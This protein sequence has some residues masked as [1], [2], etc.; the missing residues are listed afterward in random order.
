MVGLMFQPDGR[1]YLYFLELYNGAVVTSLS[2]AGW[3][4]GGPI[5]VAWAATAT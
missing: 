3:G 2:A 1:C 4:P 5:G